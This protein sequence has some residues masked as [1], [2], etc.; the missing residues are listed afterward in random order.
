MINCD[1]I[2]CIYNKDLKCILKNIHLH[3]NGSC[4][5]SIYPDIPEAVLHRQ[6]DIILKK[7]ANIEK[8][9]KF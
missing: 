6:K 8:K 1:N 4:S 5:D 9:Y 2:F 3:I 7:F